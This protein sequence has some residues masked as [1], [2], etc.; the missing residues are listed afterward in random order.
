MNDTL[1]KDII[2]DLESK[3]TNVAETAV[4]LASQGYLI[5][6]SKLIRQQ[7]ANILLQAFKHIDWFNEEQKD[8]LN[9]IYCKFLTI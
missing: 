5:N 9:A 8:N 2:D 7:W 6:R 3:I 4:I 1:T